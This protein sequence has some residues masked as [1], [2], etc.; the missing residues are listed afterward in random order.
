[1]TLAAKCQWLLGDFMQCVQHRYASIRRQ[2]LQ[3]FQKHGATE[4]N[5]ADE[6]EAPWIPIATSRYPETNAGF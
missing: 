6:G 5:A 1:M 3:K 2:H 4:N